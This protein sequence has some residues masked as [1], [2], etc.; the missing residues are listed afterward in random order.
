MG[1]IL[2]NIGV[3]IEILTPLFPGKFLLL[4]SIA[5]LMK[6]IA[7]LVLGAT[8]ASFNKMFSLSENMADVTA[9]HQS[10]GLLSY[11]IGMAFGMG[12]TYSIPTQ[13]AVYGHFVAYSFLAVI[14]LWASVKALNSVT[15]NTL[16]EQRTGIL[17]Q[18]YFHTSQII[19]PDIAKKSERLFFKPE[20]QYPA[21]VLGASVKETFEN[22]DQIKSAIT[23]HQDENYLLNYRPHKLSVVLREG[24]SPLDLLKAYFHA[25]YVKI[26]LFL[27]GVRSEK[28]RALDD[29]HWL[30]RVEQW[31]SETETDKKLPHGWT[32]KSLEF[33][34]RNFDS[35]VV[36]LD[37]AGWNTS[38]ILLF[39]HDMRSTWE[40]PPAQMPSH[41]KYDISG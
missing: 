17:L 12:I 36:R 16:N 18:E 40:S 19:S 33:T 11:L 27:G 7:G 1:D 30:E 21:I 41:E 24:S 15:L 39:A 22:V 35:F 23:T 2:H 29:P 9:K 20:L 25:Y 14:H 4:G 37:R 13:P 32:E 31:Q 28:V 26:T 8:K 6:A 38:N 34:R 10:Q 3:G 5:N